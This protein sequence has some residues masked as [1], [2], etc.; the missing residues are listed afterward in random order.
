MVVQGRQLPLHSFKFAFHALCFFLHAVS[1][2]LSCILSLKDTWVF[3][4]QDSQ[5]PVS[6]LSMLAQRSYTPGPVVP[7]AIIIL[8]DSDDEEDTEQPAS[9][10]NSEADLQP[11]DLTHQNDDPIRPQVSLL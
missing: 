6:A 9:T 8:S 11:S 2:I 10:A 5:Q 3:A 7:D 4:G 1:V